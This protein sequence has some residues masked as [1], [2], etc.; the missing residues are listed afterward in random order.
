MKKLFTFYLLGIA[1]PVFAQSPSGRVEGVH[2]LLSTEISRV[3]IHRQK[4]CAFVKVAI[5]DVRYFVRAP[6]SG[7]QKLKS[8]V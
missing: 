7:F 8:F 4:Q 3:N 5:T 6:Y 1:W 2:Q